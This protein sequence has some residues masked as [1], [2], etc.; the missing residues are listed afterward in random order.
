MRWAFLILCLIPSTLFSF[1][2]GTLLFVENGHNLVEKYTH[3]SYSHVAIVIDDEVYEAEPPK[4]HKMSSQDWITKI[5][6]D[7]EGTGS[8]EVVSVMAP[9]KPYTKEE[10]DKMKAFL[11]SQVGR[12]YSIKGYVRKRPGDGIHCAEMCSEAIEAS[13]RSDFPNPNCQFSP[14]SLHDAIEGYHQVGK[15]LYIRTKD[16]HRRT[17]CSRWG[18]WWCRKGTTCQWSCWETLTFCR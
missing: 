10:I 12:R 4:I 13:G 16:E 8:P 14:G 1:E 17:M 9:D 15:K 2:N 5:G 11:E 6:K 18:E 3:S 7:N